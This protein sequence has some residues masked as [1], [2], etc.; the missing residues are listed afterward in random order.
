[1]AMIYIPDLWAVPQS[2]AKLATW[3][4]VIAAG[5]D[6]DGGL[7]LLLEGRPPRK[8]SLSQV[9]TLYFDAERRGDGLQPSLH[10]SNL[11]ADGDS[12]SIG[13]HDDHYTY[14]PMHGTLS[15]V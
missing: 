2:D 4:R 10:G 13:I 11:H 1:M 14:T 7:W 9:E 3:V 6:D 8:V 5:E 15:H 12:H